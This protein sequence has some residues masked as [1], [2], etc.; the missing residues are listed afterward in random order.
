MTIGG[1][2][3]SSSSAASDEEASNDSCLKRVVIILYIPN[4]EKFEKSFLVSVP[5]ISCYA[6]KNLH[7]SQLNRTF[8]P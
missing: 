3:S 8:Y 7:C 6:Q 1:I 5:F 4:V 2:S